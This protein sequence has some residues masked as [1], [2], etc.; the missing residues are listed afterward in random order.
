MCLN[1][2]VWWCPGTGGATRPACPALALRGAGS[3]PQLPD[4]ACAGMNPGLVWEGKGPET[5]PRRSC[6]PISHARGP[7]SALRCPASRLALLNRAAWKD[8][9]EGRTRGA[10]CLPSWFH[11]TVKGPTFLSPPGHPEFQTG[12][13]KASGTQHVFAV[14]FQAWFQIRR[15]AAR[16][17]R[18]LHFQ[19]PVES[20]AGARTLYACIRAS[21]P[22]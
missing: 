14:N 18:C 3:S 6:S 1:L 12:V 9:P 11:C 5:R 16:R 17:R 2:L 15:N 4:A 13:P 22:L 8:L 7:R 21:S 19:R 20:R 10:G